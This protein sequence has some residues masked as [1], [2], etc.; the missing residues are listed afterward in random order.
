MSHFTELNVECQQKNEAQLIEALEEIF[1]KGNIEVHEE[2]AGLYGYG[3]D[4]RSSLAKTNPNYAPPCHLIVRRKNVGGASNDVGF[5]RNE[6]G[7]Y[8]AY[9]SD[10]DKGHNF[11]Q[12]KVDKMMQHYTSGVTVKQLKKQ[13]Y[14]ITKKVENGNIVL[15]GTKFKA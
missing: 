11:N 5:R 8:D 1:G 6:N 14:Q 15:V 7:T 2:G 9:I 12:A 13:G 3:G 4:L 10:Y